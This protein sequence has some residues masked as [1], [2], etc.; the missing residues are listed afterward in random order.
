MALRETI[1]DSEIDLFRQ[2]LVNLIDMRHELAVL[3]SKIDWA[4]LEGRFGGLYAAGVGRPGHPIRLMV[5]LQLLKYLRKASDEDIVA[6]WVENPYWQYFCGEQYF[7]HDLPIDPSLM[8]G[9]RNRIGS[10]GCEFILSLTVQTGLATKTIA[11]SSLGIVNGNLG[12][13]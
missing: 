1:H 10:D 6:S 4:A 5:G 11:K 12:E 8:A 9:F 7:R 3:S 2:E 13:I